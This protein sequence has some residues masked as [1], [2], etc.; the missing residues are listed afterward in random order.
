MKAD[1]ARY[2]LLYHYGGIYF[3]FDISMHE[4][5][6]KILSKSGL[7]VNNKLPEVYCILFEEH[8]WESKEE[9]VSADEYPIRLFMDSNYHTEALVRVAN[10]AMICTVTHPFILKVLEECNRRAF[11]DSNMV[12]MMYCLLLDQML[13][14]IFIKQ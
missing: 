7:K 2:M 3:D 6:S 14:L 8:R 4:P 1:L 11:I 10:Y 9:A 13:F 12:I 5:L